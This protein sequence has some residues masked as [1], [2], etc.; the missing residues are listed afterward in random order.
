MVAN[1]LPRSEGMTM[2]T[3]GVGT[4]NQLTIV[5]LIIAMAFVVMFAGGP[6]QF[7]H[8]VESGREGFAQGV[9]DMVLKART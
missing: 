2:R 4:E 5:V 6:S 3:S 1:G 7:M 8:T 9:H